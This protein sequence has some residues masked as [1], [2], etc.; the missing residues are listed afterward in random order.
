MALAAARGLPGPCARLRQPAQSPKSTAYRPLGLPSNQHLSNGEE[1]DSDTEAGSRRRSLARVGLRADSECFGSVVGPGA[2]VR[3]GGGAFAAAARGGPGPE[4]A[5]VGAAPHPAYRSSSL[6]A[7]QIPLPFPAGYRALA[8]QPH[9]RFHTEQ[10]L[11]LSLGILGCS[12]I[13]CALMTL[14]NRP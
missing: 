7:L 13:H 11:E 3:N 1:A 12:S 10:S 4:P 2:S 9:L 14:S 5:L 6:G 8:P